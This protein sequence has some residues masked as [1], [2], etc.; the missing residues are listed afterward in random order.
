MSLSLH[1]IP[2]I[3]FNVWYGRSLV[4]ALSDVDTGMLS[5]MT[6]CLCKLVK[7]ILLSTAFPSAR[8]YLCDE[9]TELRR[10]FEDHLINRKNLS[11]E[12]EYK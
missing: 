9:F 4:A 8:N 6:S 12:P 5:S 7:T 10:S 1:T 3:T 11:L 2:L